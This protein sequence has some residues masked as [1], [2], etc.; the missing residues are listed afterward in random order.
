[1][2]GIALATYK[3]NESFLKE[4]IASIKCQS[5]T[6]WVCHIV[7]DASPLSTQKLISDLTDSDERFITHFHTENLHGYQNFE[8]ALLY[9][10]EDPRVTEIAFADQDDI[11]HEHKLSKLL[12]LLTVTGSDLIH[13]DLE[14]IDT[15]GNRICSSVWDYE[16]RC[17]EKAD[18]EL[19]LLRNTFTGCTM[20]FSHSLLPHILPFP[21]QRQ[22]GDWYH[23]HWIALVASQ[24]GKIFHAREPL[25]RY[26]QHGNNTIGAQK[27]TGTIRREVTLW[28][29]KKGHFTLKSYRIHRDLSEAFYQRFYPT[30][31]PKKI[32]P[33]SE[34]RLDF[35]FSIF[36]LGLRSALS[37]YGA[38][39]ITLR[40]IINKFIYDC[41][42]IR[43]LCS[44]HLFSQK[45]S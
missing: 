36:K 39:G 27:N 11:W 3:P 17:P 4:Q 21:K 5:W 2:I 13:S 44:N 41:R 26:R 37:G 24:Y 31:D 6:C 34:Q 32:N 43:R 42:R 23:D 9:L 10:K 1:M 45:P 33:F 15:L 40:L 35:G 22:I 18:T 14:L 38:Q 8:R 25:V 30:A 19:L 7:D 29:D 16:N 28:F 12:T 20:M